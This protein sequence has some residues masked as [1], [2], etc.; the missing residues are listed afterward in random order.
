M[1]LADAGAPV[2]DLCTGAAEQ[3]RG[4][5]Q[6]VHP[7]GRE[8]AEIGAINTESDTEVLKLL[9][10]AP[11]HADHVVGAAVANL[12]ACSTS[13]KTML[14]VRVGY[15]IVVMHNAPFAVIP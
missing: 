5:R 8:R 9:M 4:R 1:L 14:H 12:R 13:L 6:P 11:F 7:A 10:A 2:A 3:L 15:L